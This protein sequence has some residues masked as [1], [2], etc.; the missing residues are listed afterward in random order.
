MPD[1]ITTY[2]FLSMTLSYSYVTLFILT[3]PCCFVITCT[4]VGFTW[5]DTIS[6]VGFEVDIPVHSFN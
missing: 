1:T 5:L 3:Q 2:V 4:L 6:I